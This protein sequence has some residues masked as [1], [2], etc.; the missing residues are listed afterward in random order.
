MHL[1]LPLDSRA[2]RNAFGE[3]TLRSSTWAPV[4]VCGDRKLAGRCVGHTTSFLFLHGHARAEKSWGS[5]AKVYLL[6]M[7]LCVQR[8]RTCIH[9]LCH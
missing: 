1:Y 4:V 9:R 7:K 3:L 8:N 5:E 6:G 2:T